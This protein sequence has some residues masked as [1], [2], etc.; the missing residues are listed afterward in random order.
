MCKLAGRVAKGH[1]K[2]L[3]HAGNGALEALAADDALHRARLRR[4][5]HAAKGR[6]GQRLA[7][8]GDDNAVQAAR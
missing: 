2:R 7:I 5:G 4:L 8:E 1:V 3:L 6:A